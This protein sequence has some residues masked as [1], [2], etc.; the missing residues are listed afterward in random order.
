[1]NLLSLIIDHILGR[2]YYANIVYHI[3]TSNCEIASRIF[4]TKEDARAH[5][6][7]L[8]SN[9]SFN[10]IKTISFRSRTKITNIQPYV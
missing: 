10:F 2:R 6:E 4:E 3:G 9:R 7:T 8:A 1:M 5:R